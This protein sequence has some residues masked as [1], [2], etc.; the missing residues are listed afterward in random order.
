MNP[1]AWPTASLDPVARLRVLASALPGTVLRERILP[2]PFEEVWGFLADLERSVPTFDR[3][4][5]E[6]RVLRRH[7]DQL[8]ARARV[9]GAVPLAVTF[10]IRL[11]PG[12]CWMVARPSLYVVGM[13]ATPDGDVT[14]YAQLEGLTLPGPSP[15]RTL[16]RPLLLTTRRLTKRHVDHDLNGITHALGLE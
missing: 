2:A 11:E 12:W 14:R 8:R 7:D 16:F 10:D 9:A 1:A 15:L 13:A 5:A 3:T 6:L 4:V